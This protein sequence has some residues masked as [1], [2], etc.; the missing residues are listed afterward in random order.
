MKAKVVQAYRVYL[1]NP[2]I[3]IVVLR[4]VNILGAVR[5]PGLYPVDATM[6]IADVLAVAGG[7]T[8][9]GDADQVELVRGGERV[10]V[11]LSQRTRLTESPVRS[12]DIDRCP[13]SPTWS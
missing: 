2:S 4:R 8:P 11:R 5:N 7:T 1:V 12:G 10:H 3:D 13:P 9:V 6:T